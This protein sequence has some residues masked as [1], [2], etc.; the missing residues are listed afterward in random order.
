MG[1]LT[2]LIEIYVPDEKRRR[3]F[4]WLSQAD[5]LDGEGVILVDVR[6]L[7]L[8]LNQSS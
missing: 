1:L 4:Q 8:C 6:P 7:Y 3:H 5:Y 2:K